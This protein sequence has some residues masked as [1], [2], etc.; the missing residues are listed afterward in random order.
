MWTGSPTDGAYQ[1]VL[2]QKSGGGYGTLMDNHGGPVTEPGTS[3]SMLCRTSDYRDSAKCGWESA[4]CTLATTGNVTCD[5]SPAGKLSGALNAAGDFIGFDLAKGGT[6]SKYTGGLTG[7][8]ASANDGDKDA[9]F[10]LHNKTTN[11]VVA[12][13]D[14]GV[15]SPA[16]QHWKLQTGSFTPANRSL[17]LNNLTSIVSPDLSSVSSSFGLVGWA[18]KKSQTIRP[19]HKNN[20]HSVHM[21]FANHLDVGFASYVNNIDNEYFHKYFPLALN[22]SQQV[23]HCRVAERRNKT[24]DAESHSASLLRLKLRFCFCF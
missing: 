22:V 3:Y 1:I 19:S 13:W 24:N 17:V 15:T 12:W 21:V 7:I 10:M 16:T 2:A 11:S 18:K 20:I 9:Y 14:M 5:V 23:C 8:W 6:W 4:F